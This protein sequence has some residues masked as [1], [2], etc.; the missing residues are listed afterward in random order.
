M[1]KKNNLEF[2]DNIYDEYKNDYKKLLKEM[3]KLIK[4][5]KET[6]D[7][8]LIGAAYYYLALANKDYEDKDG[9][10]TNSL[11]AVSF[12]EKT[13]NYSLLAKSY[14]CLGY[15]YGADENTQ[16][17]LSCYD[18][19][20][21]IIKRHRIYGDIRITALNNISAC[22][23]A[24]GNCEKSIG[25]LNECIGYLKKDSPDNYLDLLM[26]SI[27]L[28]N[29]YD[30]NGEPEKTREVLESAEVYAKNVSFKPLI[31][32]YY[33]KYAIISFKLGDEAKAINSCDK[34]FDYINYDLFPLPLYDDMRQ[35]SH[36]LVE[37]NDKERAGKIIEPMTVY[38]EKNIGTFEQITA[39]RTFAEYYRKFGDYER[40]LEC[41]QRLEELY[42]KHTTE[43]R[44]IKTGVYNR[45]KKVDAQIR[46]LNK[47]I[48]QSEALAN[49]EPLTML[50]NRSAMLKTASEF[51]ETAVRKKAK[52]GAIFIDIDHFK[53]FNDTYGHAKGDEIIKEVA[54]ACRKEENANIR[55]ARYGGDEYFGITIGLEDSDVAAI[56]ARICDRIRKAG[57]ENVKCP[58]GIV[59]LSAGVVNVKVTE[60]TDTI[61]EIINYADKAVY[62]AKRAGK[63]AVYFLD[64]G[65]KDENGKDNPFVRIDF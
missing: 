2:A 10:F 31:C 1:A 40:S 9:T 34:A 12:L 39:Y 24:A 49:R 21:S 6:A 47:K 37:R 18:K 13:K 55:F 64:H 53:E 29:C 15:A 4:Q 5:G 26:Y 62:Y 8:E 45:M 20:L 25:I 41:Y 58:Y 60:N 23:H 17:E 38:A 33:V 11:K 46:R 61:I 14:I 42:D 27:N 28:G 59:T 43:L 32:D 54:N 56:P 7:K 30:D 57:V 35:L 19:A 50:L 48:E 44:L 36:I 52:I 65:R 3:K 63:N 22:Y 16:L 51:L